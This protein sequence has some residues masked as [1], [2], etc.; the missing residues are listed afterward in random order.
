[1]STF[2][3]LN[4]AT[5]ALW[6]AQRGLDVTGQNVANVN[7]PG[8]SR[9]RVELQSLNGATVPAI[10]SV[11]DG[12]GYGVDSSTVT[13]IRDV[14]LE[15]RGR[16]QAAVTGRLTVEANTLSGVE[17]AFREPGDTGIQSMLSDVWAGWSDV[18]NKP[19]DLAARSQV[20]NRLE[21]LAAGI[22]TTAGTLDQQ[23]SDGHDALS[24]MVTDV[25]TTATTIAS[26]NSKIRLATLSN[27]PSNELADQRDALVM[28]LA[29]QVGATVK[30]G[31]NGTITV[32]VGGSTLVS[33]TNAVQLELQ[34]AT[35]LAGAAAD[36]PRIVTKPGGTTISVNGT[37]E[38]QITALTNTLPEYRSQLDG[39]ARQLAQSLNDTHAGGTDLDGAA[40]QPLL[41]NGPGTGAVDPADVD[42]SNITVRLTDPRKVAAAGPSPTGA[43][44]VNGDNADKLYQ[45]SLAAGGVDANYRQMIVSLGVQSAVA[46]RNLDVQT[47]ISS[48]IDA[49]RE[50]VAGVNLDEEMTN[51]LSFQH[52]YSAA[53]RL[54]T[55]IDEV[56][57]TLINMAR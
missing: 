17:K 37:A 54:V 6:A 11:G 24:A 53:A 15:A 19:K 43:A 32:L 10:H 22:R 35:D 1:M 50:S 56:L 41:G 29:G 45:L 51:M 42:A 36:P 21:T 28:K 7:T 33:G 46:T 25:N 2:G 49:A 57:D 27:Q 9:Q 16:T 23:W 5:T 13:R 20:L 30:E 8:Y 48:Q 55:T 34:G 26:L 4:R 40:G 52:A 31:E 12:V 38:G 18:A 14:F 44:T 39:I 3:G 47:T